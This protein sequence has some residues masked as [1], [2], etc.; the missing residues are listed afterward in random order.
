MS[1]VSAINELLLKCGIKINPL[2]SD[3]LVSENDLNGL[4]IVVSWNPEEMTLAAKSNILAIDDFYDSI[5]QKFQ[6]NILQLNSL[7]YLPEDFR[8]GVSLIDTAVQIK[9]L[10]KIDPNADGE[11][12]RIARL[13]KAVIYYGLESRKRLIEEYYQLDQE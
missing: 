3:T 6:K 1:S 4:H 5:F 12:A 11:D 10:A 7:D 2:D 8:I 9:G 13:I